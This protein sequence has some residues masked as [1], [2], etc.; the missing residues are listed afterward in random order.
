[1]KVRLISPI[2]AATADLGCK[3]ARTIDRRTFLAATAA[4]TAAPGF[5]FAASSRLS[6]PATVKQ[7]ELIVGKTEAGAT[8][9]LGGKPVQVSKDGSFAFGFA[10]D[11]KV[12]STLVAAFPNGSTERR[13]IV[14]GVRMYEIQRI[15]G[16][17][18][19]FV[20]PP[21][22]I[23]ERI[24]RETEIMRDKRERESDN[25]WF[26][27]GFDWPAAGIL[28][29]RYGSQRILNGE[30]R[31]P[32]LAV[33]IAAPTGTPIHAAAD[34]IVT[35]VDDFY[36]NGQFTL[37]DHGHGVSTCYQHQSKQL[38]K[39]GDKVVRGQL[40]GEVGQTGRVTGPNLHWGMNWF[41]V[42]LDP[43]HSTPTSAPPKT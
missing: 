36:L 1:M 31:A 29:S 28:S 34:G 2:A 5:V 40:I 9:T 42:S 26:T 3:A 11:R 35:I 20:S 25:S 4:F 18:E 16:L 21:P 13:Q 24:K 30:P 33:D 17:P 39:P 7:G 8:I 23:L 14:P 43:S 15:N 41:Q 32:H 38:V 19:A 6:L 22:D 10:Y 12:P 37:L 27:D